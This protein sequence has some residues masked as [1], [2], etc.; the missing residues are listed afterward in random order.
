MTLEK[1]IEK[2]AGGKRLDPKVMEAVRDIDRLREK[3]K[4]V[5]ISFLETLM[6]SRHG[7]K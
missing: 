5:K 1:K 3:V 2:A 7:K 6:K 4:D